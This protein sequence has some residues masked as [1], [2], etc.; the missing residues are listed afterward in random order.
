MTV[1]LEQIKL[2]Y[3]V[4]LVVLNLTKQKLTKAGF[5]ASIFQDFSIFMVGTNQGFS[6]CSRQKSLDRPKQISK[7]I[8]KESCQTVGQCIAQY[9]QSFKASYDDLYSAYMDQGY[10]FDGKVGHQSVLHLDLLVTR[11]NLLW[12]WT[13]RL[14]GQIYIVFKILM[15]ESQ[16]IQV[17]FRH[18]GIKVL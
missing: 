18:Q 2:R 3:E 16:G 6:G 1:T 14:L 13:Y 9:F 12:I 8:S 10:A 5:L 15:H 11:S 4:W 17:I 7:E